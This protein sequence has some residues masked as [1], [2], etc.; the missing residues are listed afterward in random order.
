[1]ASFQLP[2]GVAIEVELRATE[3]DGAVFGEGDRLVLQVP[4]PGRLKV[5]I[6]AVTVAESVAGNL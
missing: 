6:D 5:T 2:D 3:A 4:T 1:M